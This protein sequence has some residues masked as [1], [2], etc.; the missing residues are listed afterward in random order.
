M[1]PTGDNSII[2][3]YFR[4]TKEYQELYGE[5][6]ILLMQVG[7]FFEVY[8]LKNPSTHHHEVT[9]IDAFSEICNMVIAEKS[10]SMGNE[11]VRESGFPPFPRVFR[12]VPVSKTNLTIQAWMKTIPRS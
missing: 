11:A 8:A 6:T 4:I 7:T 9:H 12:D 3:D 10:F 2:L 5:K 1:S